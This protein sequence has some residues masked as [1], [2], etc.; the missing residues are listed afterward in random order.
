MKFLDIYG[1]DLNLP[2]TDYAYDSTAATFTS[3]L[4]TT[5]PT[6]AHIIKFS[7]GTNNVYVYIPTT[8]SAIPNTDQT[9][10]DLT[11][12]SAPSNSLY[13]FTGMG[14]LSPFNL[15]DM[16]DLNQ[17]YTITTATNTLL[18]N[19]FY[20]KVTTGPTQSGTNLYTEM[21]GKSWSSNYKTGDKLCYASTE[22]TGNVFEGIFS[23]KRTSE[24][25]CRCGSSTSSSSS[26]G[27]TTCCQTH[28]P[29]PATTRSSKTI[30]GPVGVSTVSG[31]SDT[32]NTSPN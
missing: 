19:K 20:Y 2:L 14:A 7:D 1:N 24:R 17:F 10:I 18:V 11:K 6:G 32:R 23:F 28:R 8:T 31:I 5:S 27:C 16:T 3:H 15:I 25:V 30:S 13:S 22:T 12:T 21:N 9:G 4:Y 29:F 26:S